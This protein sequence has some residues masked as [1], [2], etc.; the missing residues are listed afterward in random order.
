MENS[1]VVPQIAKHRIQQFYSGIISKR[2]ETKDSNRYLYTY[3]HNSIVR[4]SPKVGTTP[5]PIDG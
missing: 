4:N 2:M 5:M 3:I 1:L